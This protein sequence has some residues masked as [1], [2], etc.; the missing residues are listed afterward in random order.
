VLRHL[1]LFDGDLIQRVLA[2][3]TDAKMGHRNIIKLH[4]LQSAA[5][6]LAPPNW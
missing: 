5:I 6:R 4:H 3:S 2:S 1:E